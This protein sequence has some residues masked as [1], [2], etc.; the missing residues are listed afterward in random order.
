MCSD[1]ANLATGI[2]IGG[3]EVI[4]QMTLYFFHEHAWS[5]FECG[6]EK[7]PAVRDT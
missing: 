1:A 5:R 3:L 6:I 2:S 4:T 7:N